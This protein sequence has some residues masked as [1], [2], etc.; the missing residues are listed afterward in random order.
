MLFLLAALILAKL[1]TDAVFDRPNRVHVN[2]LVK[3]S[4]ISR[5]L[6]DLKTL[7]DVTIESGSYHLLLYE[8]HLENT[9]ILISPKNARIALTHMPPNFKGSLQI[10]GDLASVFSQNLDS[11][12]IKESLSSVS[13]S[14]NND[15]S[16]F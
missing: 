5:L 14:N 12:E 6:C 13:R 16:F 9:S 4:P 10:L 1:A 7:S 3:I 8:S 2:C 15:I 11:D